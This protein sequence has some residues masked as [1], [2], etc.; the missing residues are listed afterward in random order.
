MPIAAPATSRIGV[1]GLAVI[2]ANLAR[3]IACDEVPV[4]VHNRSV[5]RLQA[6]A[7]P[8]LCLAQLA[9]AGAGR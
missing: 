3:N 6:F 4:A 8:S 1:A 5:D 7:E 9:P 2:G